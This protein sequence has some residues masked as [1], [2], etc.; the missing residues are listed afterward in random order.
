MD[1]VLLIGLI[2]ILMIL[3]YDYKNRKNKRKR[4]HL[5][6]QSNEI[7]DKKRLEA[8]GMAHWRK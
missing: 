5:D 8:I 6:D 4:K 1:L 7:E 2:P 3:G